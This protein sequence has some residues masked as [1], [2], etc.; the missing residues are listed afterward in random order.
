MPSIFR[1]DRR[2]IAALRTC[3]LIGLMCIVATACGTQNSAAGKAGQPSGA[4]SGKQ[5]A[6][7][8]AACSSA[9]LDITLD[10]KSAGVAAGTSVIPIDFTNVTRKSC[11]LAG[12]AF[13]SFANSMKGH[14]VGATSTADRAQTARTLDLAAGKTAHLWLKVVQ[15]TNLPTAKCKPRTVA[16][17]RIKLSG[18][19][20]PI[21]ISHKFRTCAKRILGTSIL[22]VEPFQSGRARS[23]T[24][25]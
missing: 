8:G 25:R 19:A 17:L 10:L 6:A 13:V 7:A 15:A 9:Q 20:A 18:E 12:F 21:F 14:K 2:G 5:V 3:T 16:G 22:T 11:Q 4:G 1:P 23:G 24:A